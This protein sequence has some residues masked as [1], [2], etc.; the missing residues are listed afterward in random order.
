MKLLDMF[1]HHL[2]RILFAIA[3]ICMVIWAIDGFYSF[4]SDLWRSIISILALGCLFAPAVFMLSADWRRKRAYK[5]EYGTVIQAD[6]EKAEETHDGEPKFTLA[7]RL[8]WGITIQDNTFAFFRDPVSYQKF[9]L[10]DRIIVKYHTRTKKIEQ[11]MRSRVEL[12]DQMKELENQLGRGVIPQEE[13]EQK[14]KKLL[15]KFQAR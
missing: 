3:L 6:E 14:K 1:L 13:Y 4:L 15:E 7:I 12:D 2:I 11:V 9:R 10:G 5:E 8:D